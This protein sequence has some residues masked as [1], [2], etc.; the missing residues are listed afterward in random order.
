MPRKK[1]VKLPAP[2][3]IAEAPP[4]STPATDALADCY[5]FVL[6]KRQERE[7]AKAATDAVK[8]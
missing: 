1:K 6:R 8:A 2:P 7:Q 4:I 3:P 5:A